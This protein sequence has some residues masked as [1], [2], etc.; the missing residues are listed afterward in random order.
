[1]TKGERRQCSATINN[2]NTGQNTR[3][4]NRA[5]YRVTSTTGGQEHY[6]LGHKKLYDDFL[7]QAGHD[8]TRWRSVP[9]L[10]SANG[11]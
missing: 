10:A 9:Q 11:A 5:I 6:C 7:I 4:N 1:M 3:C 2:P 8:A